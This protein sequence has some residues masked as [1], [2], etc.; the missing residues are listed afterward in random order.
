MKLA[1]L[2][3]VCGVSISLAP[4]ARADGQ[5][6]S[7]GQRTGP[8]AASS[9][10]KVADAYAQ[11]LLGH[12]FEENE[13]ETNAIAAYKR[14][15]ELDPNAAEIPAQLAGL[16]LKQSKVQDAMT[17]AEA[18]LKIAPANREANRVLGTVYA[19]LSESSQDPAARGRGADKADANLATAIRHFER[20]LEGAVAESDP[21]VRATLARLYVRAN[22]Y[23]KAIPLLTDLV[24]EEPGWQDGPLMLVEAYAGAGRS[25]D[26]IAWLEER[27]AGDPRL[28]PALADFYERE[29]RWSDAAGAYARAIG[30]APRDPNLKTR[31]AS[32]LM[33]AGGRDNL[34][35]ARTTLDEVT[36]ARSTDARALYLLSQAQRRLGEYQ[37]AEASA[38]KVIAQNTK[39]PWGY[40]ALAE[41]LEA[42]RQYQ[43]VVDELAPVVAQNRGSSGDGAFDVS[44]LL[45]HLGFAYQEIGQ[46]DKAIASFE[47]ARKLAP[48]DPAVAG[49]L[50]EANIAAKKYAAAVEVAKS[51]LAQHPNDLR[52]TRLEAQALRQNGKADQGIAL[53]EEAVK[54]HADDP[55][56][57]ISLAQAYSEADRG[58]QAVKVLQD[59]LLT[60]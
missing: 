45:P 8:P 5:G 54:H 53:M 52:L 19:A 13:D 58:A 21:N 20:A 29:R 15:M 26:A 35:K 3:A 50:I 27:T 14:A 60:I 11:F 48:G 49:Y 47:D 18:S 32:A 30:R 56:A 9:P 57:Y 38:R 6:A 33:N 17:A 16:Y 2:I 25:R 59:C 1:V 12:R 28:L 31:Y 7:R 37:E 39:S 10:D 24:N 43:A 4:D 36:A 51:A 42:R 40:Y 22:A 44:L 46:H 55:V 23:D 34:E 41:A